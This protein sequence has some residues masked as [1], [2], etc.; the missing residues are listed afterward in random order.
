MRILL[1]VVVALLLPPA[2]AASQQLPPQ[3]HAT[4]AAD[5]ARGADAPAAAIIPRAVLIPAAMTI[6]ASPA[7]PFSAADVPQDGRSRL[8]VAGGVGGFLVGAA[9]GAL[10]AC[11]FNRDSYDVFCA[12]QNDTKV[13]I[14]A[15][16]GGTAGAALGSYLFRSRRR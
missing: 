8:S 16:L 15:V 4:F 2:Q 9:V 6:P 3:S 7:L 11:H 5:P 1:V 13:A 14:G 10:V 12:G